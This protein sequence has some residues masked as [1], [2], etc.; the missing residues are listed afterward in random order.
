MLAR[1]F[2]R[3][4][5]PRPPNPLRGEAFEHLLALPTHEWTAEQRQD[6]IRR[7][8]EMARHRA[9]TLADLDERTLLRRTRRWAAITVALVIAIL[10]AAGLEHHI[11]P[12]VRN[13]VTIVTA[14]FAA[15]AGISLVALVQEWDARRLDAALEQAAEQGMAQFP[16]D[17]M[18]HGGQHSASGDPAA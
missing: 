11:P 6:A 7:H 18:S 13:V 5:Q 3:A 8:Q 12:H 10:L 1:L 15:L 17:T 16:D 2:R 14:L 9:R 4:P